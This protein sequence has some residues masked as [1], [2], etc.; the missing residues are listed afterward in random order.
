MQRVVWYGAAAAVAL[1]AGAAIGLRG[2]VP[3]P[4][5]PQPVAVPPAPE[6]APAPP[7]VAAPAPK[8]AV[9]AAPSFDV[10]TVDPQGQPVIAGRAA[11]GDRV[12]V[13][14]DGKVIGEVTADGRG[15]WV[16]LPGKPLPP[17]NAQLS[18]EAT[19][20]D[21][22]APRRSNDVVALTVAPP[23]GKDNSGKGN[24]AV[25]LP[26][27]AKAAPQILQQPGTARQ[28]LS[29]DSTEHGGGNE[30]TLS[31]HASPGARLNV[32]AGNQ[33]LGSATA[34]AAGKWSLVSKLPTA[35]GNIELRLDELG[36]D[37]KVAHR[38]AAPFA[39]A[40][41]KPSVAGGTYIVRAGNS[42]WTIARQTYGEGTRYTT[43]YFANRGQIRDPDK[44]Y[45]GQRIKMPK[46]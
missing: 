27:D 33:L 12:R 4:R 20:P 41:P 25:L 5:A 46:P 37:G 36:A 1:I 8:P 6:A 23:N 15:E 3:Q 43:I 39:P 9:R 35:A 7:P 38:V 29:L 44:I 28:A 11:P 19:A 26:G 32:Y 30:L 18:L 10:V 22:S 2:P 42:L 16:L 24:T 13:L 21:G 17:G 31:G 40:A 45:P 14:S 34:D